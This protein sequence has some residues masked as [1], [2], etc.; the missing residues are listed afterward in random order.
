MLFVDFKAALRKFR[1]RCSD[2]DRDKADFIEL[3]LSRKV[4]RPD[5]KALSRH[6]SL[7]ELSPLQI[8][9]AHK[10]YEYRTISQREFDNKLREIEGESDDKVNSFFVVK[11]FLVFGQFVIKNWQY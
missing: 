1:D 11:Y 8:L 6:K 3:C 9:A 2:H 7:F 10:V 5:A 4:D